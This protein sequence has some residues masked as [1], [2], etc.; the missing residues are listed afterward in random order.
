LFLSFVTCRAADLQEH[1]E[2]NRLENVFRGTTFYA[3][4]RSAATDPIIELYINFPSASYYNQVLPNTFRYK[5][6]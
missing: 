5:Y 4:P 3:L 1:I 2:E 6:K